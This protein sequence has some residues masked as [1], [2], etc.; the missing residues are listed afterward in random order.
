VA[1]YVEGQKDVLPLVAEPL[2][3]EEIHRFSIRRVGIADHHPGTVI[4]QD[5]DDLVHQSVGDPTPLVRLIHSQ[6]DDIPVRPTPLLEDRC[7]NEPDGNTIDLGHKTV[8]RVSIEK[9]GN[10][11]LVPRSV[12][13]GVAVAR[14]Q[15]LAQMVYGARSSISI[16]LI[17]GVWCSLMVSHSLVLELVV[18]GDRHQRGIDGS[19]GS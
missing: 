15:L 10:L 6:P 18:S 7:Q 9:P 17:S 2:P 1:S 4:D 16:G 14:E 8:V 13:T 19:S 12:E 3:F 11:P 5:L